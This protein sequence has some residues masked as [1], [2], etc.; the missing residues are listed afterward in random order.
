LLT[1]TY[2]SVTVKRSISAGASS[3]AE[4]PLCDRVHLQ[5]EDSRRAEGRDVSLSSGRRGLRSMLPD[6]YQH[7][8]VEA[9]YADSRQLRRHRPRRRGISFYRQNA[10]WRRCRK[11]VIVINNNC[12]YQKFNS[13]K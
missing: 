8:G 13:G 6:G 1:K 7:V 11:N 3:M 2:G 12:Y 10:R 9:L 5:G 4:D